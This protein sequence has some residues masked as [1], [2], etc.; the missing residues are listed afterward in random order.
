MNY[1]RADE[2]YSDYKDLNIDFPFRCDKAYLDR[3]GLNKAE[4]LQKVLKNAKNHFDD[5][6][7]F[8]KFIEEFVPNAFESVK[9][10]IDFNLDQLA[11]FF[12][13][14]DYAKDLK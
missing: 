8:W 13:N 12:E 11:E 2:F 5:L 4:H 10:D 14:L 3:F 7:T 9:S 6:R 1:N